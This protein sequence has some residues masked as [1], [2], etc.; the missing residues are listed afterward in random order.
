MP[1]H[2]SQ[3]T[4]LLRQAFVFRWEIIEK[5]TKGT[6]TN[7][8]V[9]RV[10]SAFE[11]VEAEWQTGGGG[12]ATQIESLFP[13]GKI[14]DRVSEMFGY[15]ESIRNPH[16]TGELDIAIEQKDAKKVQKILEKIAPLNQKFL[17]IVTEA[18]SEII[19]ET[20]RR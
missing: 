1:K 17:E 15:W 4:T 7:D 2:L 18:F 19:H 5:F 9:E 8:D 20:G 14:R 10:R 13:A 16:K 3:L 12:D 11:R 6:M